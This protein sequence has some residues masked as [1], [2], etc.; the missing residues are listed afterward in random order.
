[1][2]WFKLLFGG[3]FIFGF[4]VDLKV[5]VPLARKAWDESFGNPDDLFQSHCVAP[6]WEK[7]H[8]AMQKASNMAKLPAREKLAFLGEN[9]VLLAVAAGQQKGPLRW[10]G[11]KI[12][13]LLHF[14]GQG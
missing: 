10:V 12:A 8:A 7:S 11:T 14:L 2:A 13:S 1:M 3:A 6:S 9:P 5:K 4:L